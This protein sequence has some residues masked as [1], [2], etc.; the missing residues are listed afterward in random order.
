MSI[1]RQNDPLVVTF[2]LTSKRLKLYY[3]IS[4]LF[5]VGGFIFAF[6]ASNAGRP[7]TWQAIFVFIGFVGLL[8][9]K[10]LTWWHHK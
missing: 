5:F 2:E 4:M 3:L 6:S 9:T 1:R 7:L 8:V 10:F